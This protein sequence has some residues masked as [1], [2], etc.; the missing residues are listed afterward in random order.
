MFRNVRL[1]D[2]EHPVDIGIRDGVFAKIGDLRTVVSAKEIDAEGA[3]MLP[4]FVES[5]IHLDTVLTAGEPERNRSGT[6]FEGIRI[7]QQRK[8]RLTREDV[9]SRAMQ[10]IRSQISQGILYVRTHA[11]ISDPNLT[12]LKALLELRERLAPYMKLQVIAFPQDGIYS[13]PDNQRRLEKALELGAD[14]VGAIPHCEYTREDGVASLQFAFALAERH[15]RMVHVFCDETDDGH[16]RFLEVTAELAIKSGLG[17]KVAASHA[18]ASS[19]YNEAYFQKLLCLTAR[20]NINIVACPLV[21][22]AMQGRFDPY[23]KGRGIARIKDFW[24]AGVNTSVAHDDMMTP[25]YPLGTGSMLQAAHMA[26]HLAHM[27]G[28]EE[29]E[30]AIRMITSR[31]AKILQIQD[32]YGIQEGNPASFVIMPVKN[33]IDLLRLQPVCRYVVSHGAIIAETHPANTFI[34]LE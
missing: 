31:A 29:M 26:V 3:L 9:I 27:T 19:Y 13:C 23:P 15:G 2:R 1:P 6:L 32:E 22:A 21:N 7:W 20:S 10:V 11:D 17:E 16:S 34:H 24:Q 5:H 28:T 18:C 4:P 12:A 25:F 30:E 8:V 33:T 14:G